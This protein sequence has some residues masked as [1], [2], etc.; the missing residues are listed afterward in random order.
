MNRPILNA[1]KS[2]KDWKES[3]VENFQVISQYS[4]EIDLSHSA[5]YSDRHSNSL[6]LNE[7]LLFYG[8]LIFGTKRGEMPGG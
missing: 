8:A 1:R 4:P 7:I 2:G 3:A 6:P 5:R